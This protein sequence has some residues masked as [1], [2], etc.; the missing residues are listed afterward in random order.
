MAT[1]TLRKLP[2]E[3]HQKIKQIQ[4]DKEKVGDK[5]TLEDLYIELIKEAL[6][7]KKAAH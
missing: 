5:I 6:E 1:I 2:S 4:L 3:V 7:T